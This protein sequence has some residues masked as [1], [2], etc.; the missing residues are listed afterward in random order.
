MV[1]LLL[2]VVPLV[3]VA[4]L[5]GAA[6]RYLLRAW[7]DYQVRIAVLKSMDRDAGTLTEPGGAGGDAQPSSTPSSD[8]RVDFLLTGIALGVIGACC[9][10]IGWNLRVGQL[11]VGI[12]LGGIFNL[13]LG[14]LLG[15]A[16]LIA[17]RL[18]SPR[19][20]TD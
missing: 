18:R 17:R 13:C 4:L 16:G 5:F 20:R 8:G 14:F 6:L 11:A 10:L 9:A 12:Y 15:L 19:S 7:V 3:V 2:V 1:D